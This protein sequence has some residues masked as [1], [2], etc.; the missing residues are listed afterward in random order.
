MRKLS[1][2]GM[3][4]VSMVFR[5]GIDGGQGFFRA[6]PYMTGLVKVPSPLSAMCTATPRGSS[7]PSQNQ[8]LSDIFLPGERS[9][10]NRSEVKQ[11]I[12]QT[13]TEN[14]NNNNNNPEESYS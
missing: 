10:T 9:K 11:N 5:C 12:K 13:E 6:L 2:A 8:A 7:R 14:N 4:D 3:Q 1:S